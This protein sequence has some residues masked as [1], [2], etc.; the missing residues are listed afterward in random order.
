MAVS[1]CCLMLSS[2]LIGCFTVPLISKEETQG[3]KYIFKYF[4]SQLYR[5]VIILYIKR[6][7]QGAV[8]NTR[9]IET[10]FERS[11]DRVIVS[12]SRDAMHKL[13]LVW[14]KDWYLEPLGYIMCHSPVRK[15]Y[16]TV[17]KKY[18]N[19]RKEDWVVDVCLPF[20][21]CLHSVCERVDDVSCLRKQGV[22][23]YANTYI[24]TKVGKTIK[25]LTEC[26][27]WTNISWSYTFHRIYK[28]I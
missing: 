13:G 1:Q 6:G 25:T 17:S 5:R 4:L 20:L 22:Q 14:R 11:V 24:D 19:R 12:L 10:A 28:Y 3:G 2:A 8:I 18:Y 26:F 15:R 7:H 27:D 9:G 21:F 23:R 16:S